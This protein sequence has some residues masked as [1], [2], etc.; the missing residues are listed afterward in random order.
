MSRFVQRLG[1]GLSVLAAS[2]SVIAAGTQASAPSTA[3][4]RGLWVQRTALAS[5][6]SIAAMVQAAAAGGFNTLLV[7]VRGR[8][9]AFYR[10]AIEPRSTDLDR[11]PADFDPLAT[12]IKL[13]R[14]AGLAVHAWVNVNLV[15]SGT[16]LPRSRDH[17][18]AQHPDWLMVPKPLA[19]SLRKAGP[20]SPAYLGTL[21]RWTRSQT[22]QVEGLYLSPVTAS[23]RAYTT[24]VVAELA[25]K[26][27][28]DGI[29]LD[30]I[31]YPSAEFDFSEAAMSAF[32]DAVSGAETRTERE[33]LDRAAVAN[34]AA[35]AEA[36]PTAW[37]A[38]HR[39][40]L[41]SLAVAIQA[42]VR[43]ARPGITLSAAVIG[44]SAE[45][46]DSRYQDWL[47]WAKA[48]HID[49]L[50][51]ML[52]S[53]STDQFATVTADIRTALGTTPFWAG[54]GAYRLPV[55]GTIE[56]V[57]L[58]RRANADGVLLF[59]YS[60]LTDAAATSPATLSALR[61]VLLEIANG[62]GNP[63]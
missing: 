19:A 35:W 37:A 55:D 39:E 18:V 58:A 60:Q 59:S 50:C 14:P 10:S 49:V 4:V 7:Q 62:S 23:S 34:P 30:Y 6:E 52:Y 33:R 16:N 41:T 17:V 1:V 24:S 8:G 22:D 12:V 61:P 36:R 32:R 21:A 20:S 27:E 56:R 53:L 2:A 51:P 25:T 42:A 9:E 15:A 29:H 47:A 44:V 46:R 45:A 63:R 38:F 57:R 43:A 54:I 31:R 48:G 28:L 26:Y 5:P 11:Q 3:S 13:A 40:R